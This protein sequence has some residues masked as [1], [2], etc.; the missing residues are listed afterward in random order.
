MVRISLIISVL[1]LFF[2]CARYLEKSAK[3]PV[4]EGHRVTFRVRNESARVV[5]VAGD[6]NNWAMGDAAEGEAFV[7]LMTRNDSLICWERTLEL[8]RGRYKYRF[9]FNESVLMLDRNNPRIVDDTKG[10]KANLLIV[11]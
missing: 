6:W 3:S 5:Q 1:V 7:G 11:P 9:L 8:E 10:G 2:S 4:I